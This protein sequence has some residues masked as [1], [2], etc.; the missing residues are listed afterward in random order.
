[1][2]AGSFKRGNKERYPGGVLTPSTLVLLF[3]VPWSMGLDEHFS[4]FPGLHLAFVPA[5]S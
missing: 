5:V 1:M 3:L 2:D 4:V